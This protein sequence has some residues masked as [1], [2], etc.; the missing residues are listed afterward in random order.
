[1][2]R[3][4]AGFALALAFSTIAFA[5]GDQK[6]VMGAVT[7]ISDNSITVETTSNEDSYGDFE[8]RDEVPKE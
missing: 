7:S 4:V 3:I 2:K 8:R 6:H 5:H 1:M